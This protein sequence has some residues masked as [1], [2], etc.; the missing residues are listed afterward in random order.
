MWTLLLL[1]TLCWKLRVGAEGLWTQCRRTW[2]PTHRWRHR[3]EGTS[4]LWVLRVRV[5]VCVCTVCVHVMRMCMCMCLFVCLCVCKVKLLFYD[6]LYQK[7]AYFAWIC[8]ITNTILSGLVVYKYYLDDKKFVKTGYIWEQTGLIEIRSKKMERVE[9]FRY[10]F[11][12]NI[13]IIIRLLIIN[14]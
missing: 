1:G 11:S 12:N 10:V 3:G 2:P 13:I 4:H 7:T 5:C 9:W 6:G 14:K 8:F